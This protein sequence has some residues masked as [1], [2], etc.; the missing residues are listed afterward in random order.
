MSLFSPFPALPPT[1][2]FSGGET[3]TGIG[4]AAEIEALLIRRDYLL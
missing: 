4:K 2:S 3:K 1:E